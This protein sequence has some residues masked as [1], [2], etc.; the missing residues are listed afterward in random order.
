M[1]YRFLKPLPRPLS[2]IGYLGFAP[3]LSAVA[4]LSDPQSYIVRPL[5]LSGP[6]SSVCSVSLD[7]LWDKL[8]SH[9]MMICTSASGGSQT[10][11]EA[12][13]LDGK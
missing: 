7:H 13:S 5:Q 2:G 10:D 1:A 8:W 12:L 9:H 4:P 6:Q 3:S 11:P